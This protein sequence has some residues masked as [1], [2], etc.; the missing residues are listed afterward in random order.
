MVNHPFANRTIIRPKPYELTMEPA[1]E[2]SIEALGLEESISAAA[3]I[4]WDL[5]VNR[6]TPGDDYIINVQS[7]KKPYQTEDLAD[8]PLFTEVDESAFRR[9]TYS[10]FIA[11][12][13]NYV[14]QTG[15]TEE[16]TPTEEAENYAFLNAIM[17][18]GPM[19]YCHKYCVANKEDIPSDPD[20]FI[21]L[22]YKIWFGLYKR[23]RGG[24]HDSSGFEHVFAG[25]IKN[26]KVSGFHNWIYF[27]LEEMQ[28]NVNYKGYI[29]P[30]GRGSAETNDDDHILTLQF[31]W[32][33]VEKFVG[34]SFIG[35][36]PEFEIAL[37]TMCFLVGEEENIIEID[38]GAD[39]FKLKNKTYTYANDKIGTSYVEALEHYD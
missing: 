37:Y 32:Y 25:E 8:D 11:L 39:V 35:V 6:L 18:T 3:Q 15:E 9:P 5:D 20:E 33:G 34:T 36:S 30:R 1:E 29:K 24:G 7:G 27:Y 23:S 10:T 31:E 14:S 19:Q 38:T 4:L 16:V 22:L 13:D 26:E 21:Q 2:S 17:Q 28:G 12:L